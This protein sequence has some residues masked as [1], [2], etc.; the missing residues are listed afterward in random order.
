METRIRPYGE[1]DLMAIQKIW[2]SVVEGGDAFPGET[3][4]SLQ[5]CRDYFARQSLTAVAETEGRVA[6][7]YILHPNNIGRAG[8]IANASYAVASSARGRGIGE[9]LV[10]HSLGQLR[11]HGFTGL[12]FNA[13]VSTNRTA[14]ALYEKLGFTRVGTIPG[15]FRLP[16]GSFVD[17]Y[18][19]FHAAPEGDGARPQGVRPH[20]AAGQG[21]AAG[22]A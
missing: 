16:D 9:A 4:L 19:Y 15:G 20:G 13:V 18:L 6:G 8:H 10:R 2:N 5:E 7:L 22:E 1:S 3:P 21:G 11:P 14:I 12:Q 17:I